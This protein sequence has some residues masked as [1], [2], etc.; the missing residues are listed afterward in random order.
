MTERVAS[1]QGL[2]TLGHLLEGNGE[3]GVAPWEEIEEPFSR[4]PQN[5]G[6]VQRRR[7][8]WLLRHHCAVFLDHILATTNLLTVA[9]DNE[10]PKAQKKNSLSF[11]RFLL[12]VC[13]VF[14]GSPCVTVDVRGN[15]KA[16][17]S[18]TEKI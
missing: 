3:D 12:R 13:H 10:F 1:L 14:T 15:T 6:Q 2:K 8:T 7:C 18:S 17:L 9:P 4:R 16:S 11:T 5:D